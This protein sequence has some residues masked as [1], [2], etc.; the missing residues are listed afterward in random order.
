MMTHWTHL[1]RFSLVASVAFCFATLPA[2]EQHDAPETLSQFSS[3]VLESGSSE[4]HLRVPRQYI[5]RRI[6]VTDH[7]LAMLVPSQEFPGLDEI[8]EDKTVDFAI[9]PRTH[10]GLQRRKNRS[11]KA[12]EKVDSDIAGFTKLLGPVH[13]HLDSGQYYYFGSLPNGKGVFSACADRCTFEGQYN[14]EFKYVIGI[15]LESMR[16]PVHVDSIARDFLA[17]LIAR[18]N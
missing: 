9:A 4:L 5:D 15:E 2:C 10:A 7:S 12:Y 11:L 8:S 16:R 1:W 17:T 6:R 18:E 13:E 14:D 3:I